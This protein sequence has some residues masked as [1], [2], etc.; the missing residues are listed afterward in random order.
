VR[1]QKRHGNAERKHSGNERTEEMQVNIPVVDEMKLRQ[2]VYRELDDDSGE[3]RA[4]T[5][6]T[7]TLQIIDISDEDYETL[8]DLL[9]CIS[10]KSAVVGSRQGHMELFPAEKAS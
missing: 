4:H 2:G 8:K 1:R 9:A 6:T 10:T 5:Q 7:L 3:Y